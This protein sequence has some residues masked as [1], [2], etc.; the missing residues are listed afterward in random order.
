MKYTYLEGADIKL[1]CLGLGSEQ[2]GGYG[3]GKVS[4]PE[5]VKAVHKAI[6]SGVT[7]FDTAPIYGLGQSEEELGKALGT[8]RKNVIVA[9]KVGL[10]W[11]KEETFEKF[12]DSSPDNIE[13]EVNMSLKRLGTDYIDIYQIHWPDP[14]TPIE[15]ALFTMK[16]LKQSGKIRCI[17]C[18]NFSLELLKEAVKYDEIRT[19]QVPFNL[20]DRKVE[21]ALLHFCNENNIGVL[22]YSPIARGFLSGKYDENTTFGFDDQRSRDGDEYFQREA[23]QKNLKVLEKLKFVAKKLN[24]TPSQIALRWVMQNPYVAT[25]IVGVKNVAQVEENVVAS[26]FTLSKEDIEFLS[27]DV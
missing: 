7:F 25:A 22:A 20:I 14:R 15:D 18:C 1:S 11:K 3:W 12:T 21:S 9:T 4:I 13:K 17:G 16:K 2:L 10:V 5:M 24:K 19:I 8:A 27:Q 6:D 23:F 26:D